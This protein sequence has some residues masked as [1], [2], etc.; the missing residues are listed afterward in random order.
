MIGKITKGARA[1]AIGAYLHGAGKANE[2]T[3]QAGDERRSGGIVI[4]SNHRH[5]VGDT[6]PSRWAVEMRKPLQLRER[7]VAKPIWQVSLALKPGES[8]TEAQWADAAQTFVE[9]LGVQEH[10]W[11]AVH[12]G[13]S[14]GGNDHIHI[15]VNRVGYD[16]QLWQA[17]H[18]FRQVQ[19][20]CTSL[21]RQFG[22]SHAPRTRDA[23][24]V[25]RASKQSVHQAHRQAAGQPGLQ[26]NP[27]AYRPR[28]LTL[29][30]RIE[31]QVAQ[32]QAELR[33]QR[34]APPERQAFSQR[35]EDRLSAPAPKRDPRLSA[36]ERLRKAKE[37]ARLKAE[38]PQIERPATV[39]R[40]VGSRFTR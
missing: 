10:P 2:H 5:F 15:V 17:K 31:Q 29:G 39:Q 14:A 13:S 6:D 8:L 16:G 23:Q 34:T 24:S 4:G 7:A 26:S 27:E 3:Y 28:P 36:V 35:T 25:A 37:A 9:K 40:N 30:Q 1:G 11:V 32:K 38:K 22:L 20:A 33:G 19:R 12:H 18:D 21:E